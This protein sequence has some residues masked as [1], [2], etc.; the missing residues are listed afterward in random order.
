MMNPKKLVLLL[1]LLFFLLIGITAVV[2]DILVLILSVGK[3]D[4]KFLETVLDK[5]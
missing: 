2:I 5:L 4:C 1:Y 3:M